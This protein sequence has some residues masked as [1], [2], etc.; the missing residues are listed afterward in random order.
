MTKNSAKIRYGITAL[1]YRPY[2]ILSGTVV[3]GSVN[4]GANTISVQTNYNDIPI[5]GVLLNAIGDSATGMVLVPKED[6]AVIIG[7]IDGPG[8][9]TLINA[10]ELEQAVIK[11][12]EVTFTMKETGIKMAHGNTIFDIGE[13]IKIN[14]ESESLFAILND[15]ITAISL[16]TVTTSTGPSSVPVNVASFTALLSRLSNLLS[17]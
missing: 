5:E 7:S 9:W 4:I 8:Q 11:I 2:E 15:L 1:A 13:L 17:A 6:S 16:L 12:G 10:S 3:A 14:T